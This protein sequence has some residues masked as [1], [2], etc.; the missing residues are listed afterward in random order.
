MRLRVMTI[1]LV[2]EYD[3]EHMHF[4]LRCDAA[5]VLY[6]NGIS[7]LYICLARRGSPGWTRIWI[8]GMASE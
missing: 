7:M 6:I 4:V 5:F 2:K 3:I 1:K 8:H